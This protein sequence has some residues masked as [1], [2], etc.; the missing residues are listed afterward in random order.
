M[1]LHDIIKKL[2]K[3][4]VLIPLFATRRIGTLKSHVRSQN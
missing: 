2:D 3:V 4:L 1:D